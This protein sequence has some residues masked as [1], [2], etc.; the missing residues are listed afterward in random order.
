MGGKVYDPKVKSSTALTNM[1][2]IH[3]SDK[4][5]SKDYQSIVR[6]TYKVPSQHKDFKSGPGKGPRERLREQMMKDQVE[7]EFK[8]RDEEKERERNARLFE[9]TSSANNKDAALTLRDRQ[10]TLVSGQRR[11]PYYMNE[12]TVTYYLHTLLHGD[13]ISFPI[14]TI[15]SL[16][17]PWQRGVAISGGMQ[18]IFLLSIFQLL[19]FF[20][21]SKWR[22][23]TV[24]NL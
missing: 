21:S 13:E 5:D 23:Q 15:G 16:S 19:Y 24:R 1:R 3:H 17:N 10:S 8:T 22:I 6:S 2:V 4:V 12:S 9:T 7:S 14:T 11:D 20:R 18:Y